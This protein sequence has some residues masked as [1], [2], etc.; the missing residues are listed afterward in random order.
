MAS[1]ILTPQQV[2]R[3]HQEGFLILLTQQ[4]GLVD[5]DELQRWTQEVR[6]W[7][8]TNGKWMPYE[9]VNS[10][11][12]KQLLRTE[13]F[14]DYHQNFHDFLCG[15]KMAALLKE[16]S[17]DVSRILGDIDSVWRGRRILI[18]PGHVVVQGQD[19]L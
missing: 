13:N 17:G 8:K 4:H 16:V 15:E 7:P 12:E 11:G 10:E 5:P 1:S 14:V 3:F 19:Q 9:E 18:Y 6:S 2:A